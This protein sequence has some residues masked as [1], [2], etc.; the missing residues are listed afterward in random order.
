LVDKLG[1]V[2]LAKGRNVIE[3]NIKKEHKEMES[4]DIPLKHV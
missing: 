4:G 1:K 3:R 2:E